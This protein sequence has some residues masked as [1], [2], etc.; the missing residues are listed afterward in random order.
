MLVESPNPRIVHEDN[1]DSSSAV[2]SLLHNADD[3]YDSS[4]S[5]WNR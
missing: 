2:P 3:L 4:T 5:C 1:P